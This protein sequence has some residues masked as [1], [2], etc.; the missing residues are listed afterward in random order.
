MI[1]KSSLNFFKK[2]GY[3]IIKN[4][5]PKKNINNIF[6]AL[7]NLFKKSKYSNEYKKN[8]TNNLLKKISSI[9]IYIKKNDPK[10][11]SEL[12][13]FFKL[14]LVLNKFLDENFFQI[15]SK[16]ININTYNIVNQQSVLRFDKPNEKKT[17]IDYHQDYMSDF[18]EKKNKFIG[19]TVWC[20]LERANS[21]Y[22]GMEILEGSH[23]S[24]WKT[25]INGSK[26]RGK[27]SKY[28]IDKK[29][30][31][32]YQ[33]KAIIPDLKGGDVVIFDTRLIHKSVQ[34]H[35]SICRFTAQFRC[36]FIN[37]AKI[38]N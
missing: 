35:S 37:E 4:I 3:L 26:I 36:G 13:E 17:I 14:S 32:I 16:K 23:K 7:D 19:F 10:F 34:N 2:N 22:G 24:G 1:D 27:T 5:I 8:K 38:F 33:K 20:P 12:Y 11:G 15:L 6:I 18:N 30:I 31:K 9:F 29:T 25:S 28:M 21:Y